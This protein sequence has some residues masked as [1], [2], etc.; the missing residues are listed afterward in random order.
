MNAD[1]TIEKYLRCFTEIPTL[2]FIRFGTRIPVVLPQRI[3]Q[4]DKLLGI[5][6]TYGR[7]KQII[8]V[9]QFNHPRELTPDAVQA[10]KA[11]GSV[12]CIVRNQTVLLKGINDHADV[13]AQL[14]NGLVSNGVIPYYIFQC[15]PVEGVQNQFQVPLLRGV[16]IVENAKRQMN[17][18]SKSVRYAMSHPTGKIEILG[19]TGPNQMLFKYHQA[20]NPQDHSRIFTQNVDDTQCWLGEIAQ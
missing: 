5:L 14:M 19:K 13:L 15:R 16:K 9:T 8:I 10:I 11:L 18:Q 3:V 6:E 20:K 12:G 2:D 1:E 17:G 7:K 4:D